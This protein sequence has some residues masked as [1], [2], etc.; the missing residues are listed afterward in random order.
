MTLKNIT[1][2]KRLMCAFTIFT[3]I[4]LIA[5]AI[6]FMNMKSVGNKAYEIVEI[7]FQKAALANTVLTNLQ[8]ISQA[9][10]IAVYTKDKSAFSVVGEKRKLYV[11]ALGKLEKIETEQAG[12]DL[13]SKLKADIA[14]GK[15]A[16][17]KMM[18]AVDEGN[19]EEATQLYTTIMI[20]AVKTNTETVSNI[21]KFQKKGI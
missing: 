7:N 6:S 18:K 10:G 19:F 14:S 15:E 3:F 1:I 8:A 5:C 17:V 20:P 4:V 16:N 12:K 13:I 2:G 9:V 21:L 11:D